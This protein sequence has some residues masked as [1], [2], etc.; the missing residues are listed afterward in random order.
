MKD[1]KFQ[2]EMLSGRDHLEEIIYRC[3][4]YIIS[5]SDAI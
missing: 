3:E 2:S 1:A 5:Y 4:N